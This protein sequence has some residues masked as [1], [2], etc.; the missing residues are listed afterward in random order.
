MSKDLDMKPV[1]KTIR[2][3][4]SF[5][6]SSEQFKI[7]SYQR[8]YQWNTS[9]H[10]DKLLEDIY[11]YVENKESNS[12]AYFFG[13]LIT[14]A[15]KNDKNETEYYLIIDG[16][17]RTITFLLL[18]KALHFILEDYKSEDSNFDD[19]AKETIKD[20]LKDVLI[21]LYKNNKANII[22]FINEYNYA[23]IEK[24]NEHRILI[25]QSMNE[26]N[27]EDW[28]NIFTAKRFNNINPK[29][30]KNL[31]KDNKF[32]HYYRNLKFFYN[33]IKN[34]LKD[35]NNI[36]EEID[37]LSKFI[38]TFLDECEVIQISSDNINQAV[39]I[40]NSLNS[41]GC[42]LEDADIICSLAFSNCQNKNSELSFKSKWE[43]IV[44]NTTENLNDYFSVTTLLQQLMYHDR[45]KE[46]VKASDKKKTEL[47]TP[48]VKDY[49][50]NIRKTFIQN[51]DSFSK[52]L[53]KLE[54]IWEN[55]LELPIVRLL[56]KIN[57]NS[58]LFIA[59]YFYQKYLD[60]CNIALN[61]IDCSE[62]NG[63]DGNTDQSDCDDKTEV[64]FDLE[65]EVVPYLEELLKLFTILELS[66]F[67][68]QRS[69][70]KGFLFEVNDDIVSEK[71]IE[72]VSSKF[73]DNI[74]KIRK[75]AFDN[76]IYESIMNYRGDKLVF[77][78]EYLFAKEKH[79]QFYLDRESKGVDIEHIMPQS[80]GNLM[81]EI[82][83]IDEDTY[84]DSI[85]KL[86]NKILLEHP[87]NNNLSDDN[88]KF[89]KK[90]TIGSTYNKKGYQGYRDSKYLIASSLCSYSKDLWNIE[91][92]DN[93]TSKAAK[94]IESFILN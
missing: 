47:R 10:C 56:I 61:N 25:N 65:T 86:G 69:E 9:E 53:L 28:D 12:D 79:L 18:L 63:I 14:V 88:F 49:F 20:R 76:K 82:Y 54:Q 21:T 6:N 83:M 55:L 94:R 42:P 29:K 39:A 87:I 33:T 36:P 58:H 71:S 62:S 72:D 85:E 17:Q 75:A 40:F 30:F 16:Q 48:G 1:V 19:V 5:N 57:N 41:K 4:L 73:H 32:T 11:N 37:Y 74:S 45:A 70:F 60:R 44:R 13:N 7:P 34:K 43:K 52:N 68:Y 66:E 27:F 24:Y 92:I 15:E 89:K 23:D 22:R 51:P 67:S 81:Y 93:A 31:K 2:T 80:K 38:V 46:S 77:V 26:T 78:N 84:I 91:D 35:I 59:S 90:C 3:Y 8:Q 64:T 50:V